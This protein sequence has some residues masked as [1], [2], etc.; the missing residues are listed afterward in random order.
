[1]KYTS[2]KQ[3]LQSIE[4]EGVGKIEV[5]RRC[6]QKSTSLRLSRSGL[7]V[8][9]TNY[10]TPLHS[11][12]SFVTAHQSWLE[13][14]RQKSGFFEEIEI[15]DGQYVAKDLRI[16]VVQTN[17]P[18]L[19]E[20]KFSYRKGSQEVKVY[21]D[22]ALG[23]EDSISLDWQE[24][25][26]LEKQVVRALR[27]R[28]V[29]FLPERLSEVSDMMG[30][31]YKK[32]TIRNTSSR[33]GSCSSENSIS[34]SVWLMLLPEKLVDY[35]LVHE[36]AHTR[37]KNHRLEFWQEVEKWVPNHKDLRK[38]LKKYSSQVWW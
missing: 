29:V 36:L 37:F 27:E 20:K 2:S 33:W 9:S 17:K 26:D 15:F 21:L 4:V 1:M 24:K 32:V 18:N 12:K 11:L 6:G 25:S 10:S 28:A 16:R 23:V 19:L 5:R 30:T 38:E 35:V 31:S 3:N 7:P 14:V 22:T 13:D 8:L 34:L